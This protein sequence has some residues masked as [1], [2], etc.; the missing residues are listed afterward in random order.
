ML[1]VVCS[2]TASRLKFCF[3]ESRSAFLR[4][5]V[6][7]GRIAIFYSRQPR[8]V[9]S[10]SL[11]PIQDG[12]L[13]VHRTFYRESRSPFLI[14]WRPLRLCMFFVFMLLQAAM[15]KRIMGTMNFHGC[16]EVRFIK[17]FLW[18]LFY[19]TSPGG[20]RGLLRGGWRAV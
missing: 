4:A 2:S 6:H 17:Q 11:R 13:P 8:I 19:T 20:R 12:A 3:S 5:E 1:K 10:R 16:W 18:H 7:P 15:D 9:F 14:R